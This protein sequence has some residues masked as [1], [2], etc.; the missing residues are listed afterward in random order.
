M[1]TKIERRHFKEMGAS[2][3]VESAR[4]YGA[5]VKVR[6]HAKFKWRLYHNME[7]ASSKGKAHHII[8]VALQYKGTHVKVGGR[9]L[10]WRKTPYLMGPCY[11]LEVYAII[12]VAL[13]YFGPLFS[14]GAPTKDREG[15]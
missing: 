10:V 15:R 7:G 9:V 6:A 12:E 13:M 2:M 14:K 11:I 5:L 4:Y 1:L 3:D 8:E